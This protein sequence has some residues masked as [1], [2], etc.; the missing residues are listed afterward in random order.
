MCAANPERNFSDIY[1]WDREILELC[2]SVKK[3]E[4]H[5]MLDQ[6]RF[7]INFL[8]V[9]ELYCFLFPPHAVSNQ[10]PSA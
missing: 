5:N 10:I 8:Y 2:W 3:V 1:P 9:L 7:F 6:G 4:L